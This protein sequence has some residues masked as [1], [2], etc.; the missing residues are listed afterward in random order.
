MARDILKVRKV[1]GTLVVTLAQGVLEEVQLVEGDRVL[2]EALPPKRIL[3]SKEV[4]SVSSTRGVEL[5][6][7]ILEAKR[8]SFGSQMDE[9]VSEYQLNG[10]DSDAL[11]AWLK[12]LKS[13]RDKVRVAIAEKS[14]ELFELQGV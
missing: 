14:L 1:G 3:I 13:E 4:S 12:H 5:E 2:I 7:Q 11:D 8:D 6:L 9:A 10:N